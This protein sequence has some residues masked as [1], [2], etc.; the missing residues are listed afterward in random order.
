[1]LRLAAH[2]FCSNKHTDN[3]KAACGLKIAC[4][5]VRTL[6]D[7][8]NS[9]ERKTATVAQHLS[10]YNIDISALSETRFPETGELEE[11]KGGYTFYWS[12]RKPEEARQA[13]V[14]FAIKSSI[15]R[16]LESLPKGINDRLMTLR[17]KTSNDQYVT[18]ISVYAPTM[19]STDETKEKFYSDLRGILNSTPYHDKIVLLGDFNARVGRDDLVWPGVLGKHG[20]GSM[21]SNGLLL[22]TL[23]SEFDLTITSTIFQQPD[24]HKTSWKHVRSNHWHLIDYVIVRRRDISSVYK[25][26]SL[27][28]PGYL[29]DHKLIRCNMSIPFVAKKKNS[30]VPMPK[31]I[32]VSV[33][34]D[35][36]KQTEL[37]SALDEKLALH[38]TSPDIEH[39]WKSLRDCVYETSAEVCGFVKRKN[40]D[41]FD[42][43]DEEIVKLLDALHSSHKS[44]ISDKSSSAKKYAYLEAKRSSQRRLRQ[45]KES[46]W[47]RKAEEL[48]LAADTHNAKAFYEGLKA[49]YGP[50]SSGT[51]P[52]HSSDNTLLTD[53]DEILKRWA[54]H[55][56]SILNRQAEVDDNV[57]NEIP[58]RPVLQELSG[59]PA[60]AEVETAINQLSN[61]KS[62]GK[63]GI[64]AEIFKH[65]G[66]PL[67]SGLTNLF[68]VIWLEGAVPQDFKDASIISI[69]KNKG[70]RTC[71]DDYRG[72]SLLSIA[73]KVLARVILNRINKHL[74]PSVYPE[75]QCGFRAGRGT[76]DMI[77]GLRQVQEKS[78]E[79]NKDLFMVFVDLTKAF[80]TVSRSTLWKVLSKLGVPCDMLKVICSFHD[81]MEAFVS[82]GG[83]NSETFPVSSGTKQGCVLAPVLFAL[84][85][86]VMLEHAFSDCKK[87]VNIQF[88]TDEHAFKRGGFRGKSKLRSELLRDL[89]F[90]DDAALVAHSLEEMQDLVDRFSRATKAFGLTISIKKTEFLHQPKAGCPQTDSHILIDGKPLKN[91]DK[92]VYLGS[93]VQSSTLL[94]TEIANRISRASSSFG[95]LNDRLWKDHD[96]SLETKISV[97]IAGVLTTLLSG[98]EAWTAYK[99]QI[100]HI[101]A[102]HMRC[103][104]SIC[105]LKWSDKVRNSDILA[106]CNTMGIDA[107]VIRNQCRWAGHVVRMDDGRIPKSLLFGQLSDAPRRTGRPLLLYK[108][109]LKFNLKL[110]NLEIKDLLSMAPDRNL[111]RSTY[112]KKLAD[113]ECERLQHYN[114]L[115]AM[116]KTRLSQ[117]H[118]GAWYSCDQCGFNARSKPGIAAHKR[119]HQRRTEAAA[120]VEAGLVCSICS[121]ICKSKGGLKIHTNMMHKT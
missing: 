17:L 108:H 6:Q 16:N 102:F 52:I 74:V 75:S 44:W 22:L 45:M 65:G 58:Q 105:G 1:M 27:C 95:Q 62:P 83:Q 111:W 112:Q 21:N 15:A 49:V 5:N 80:D 79:H 3:K 68:V 106:K 101:D 18:L 11:V 66:A 20:S 33:L 51:S 50:K 40:Q 99:K 30:R 32:D 34:S 97:Y 120:V 69:F 31:K 63:D 70:S 96:I 67:V 7:N 86:S 109:K 55:F 90:A 103:L 26:Q 2:P 14:G 119:M 71:C 98:S 54:E 94:D 107:F 78:R 9:L 114:E 56:D 92:F 37:A 47:R 118:T 61:G 87:G 88:R 38:E 35:K 60:L 89:L 28:T 24:R 117:P 93:W 39:T 116:Y 77:F 10:R 91:V 76:V 64:P 59:A 72:I 73:G 13:G 113:F 23:C 29:S 85:F 81:G 41:W 110:L 82:A 121:K 46:W 53:R 4:W 84:F 48:Q 57:I 43:S 8:D 42:E 19:M 100:L 104:R 36:S 12:G 115:S 25:T